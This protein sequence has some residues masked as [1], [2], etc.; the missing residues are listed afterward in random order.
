MTDLKTIKVV[1]AME[2]QLWAVL[3]AIIGI[4]Y[5]ANYSASTLFPSGWMIFW[6]MIMAGHDIDCRRIPNALTLMTAM[7]ALLI[8]STHGFS[9]F[10]QAILSGS[11]VFVV[12][13]ILFFMGIVGGGDAK[14]VAALAM[15]L[16]IHD[17]FAFLIC[18]SLAGGV[19][20]VFQ[21]IVNHRFSDL[22]LLRASTKNWRAVGAGI[23]LPYGLAILGGC[24]LWSLWAGI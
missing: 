9:G 24:F 2:G 23:T 14:A 18:I 1:D 10:F 21:L 16:P 7:W 22:L 15:F 8:G 13:A 4:S 5:I 11:L 20:S 19:Q 12:M 17:C 6:A 3:P